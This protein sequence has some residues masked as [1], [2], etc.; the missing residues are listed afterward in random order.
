MAIHVSG[1][2][3]WAYRAGRE[4]SLGSLVLGAVIAA[5]AGRRFGARPL[6]I[7]AIA[8]VTF[9]AA[10]VARD[11]VASDTEPSWCY[12]DEVRV[13]GNVIHTAGNDDGCTVLLPSSG[14]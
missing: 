6:S 9:V 4:I 7:A 1:D 8:L 3:E 13:S 5:A 14:D 11:L 12:A 2:A 10:A